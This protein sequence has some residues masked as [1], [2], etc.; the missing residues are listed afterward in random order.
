MTVSHLVKKFFTF[1]KK[2]EAYYCIHKKLSLELVCGQLNPVDILT[3]YL[4][5]LF[6]LLSHVQQ[7]LTSILSLP[8]ILSCVLY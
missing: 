5:L 8:G 2:L 1:H 7:N 4:R 3:P 6:V